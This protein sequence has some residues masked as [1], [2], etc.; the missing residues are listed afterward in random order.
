MAVD[1]PATQPFIASLVRDCGNSGRTFK[2]ALIYAVP[3]GS[4]RIHEAGRDWLAWEDINDDVP[5]KDRLDDGQKQTLDK[6]L[7]HAKSDFREAI[8]RAYR[9]LYL[10]GKDNQLRSIDLG[11]ITSSAGNSLVD[12][13]LQRLGTGGLDEIVEHVPPR[14]LL[15]Y[16]PAS[17]SEWSTK[18]VRDAFYS[19]PQ[20]PRLLNPDSVKRMIADGVTEGVIGYAT[21]DATGRLRPEELKG[22]LFENNVD[23]SDDVFI[24]TAEHALKLK[25][26]P[27]LDKLAIKPD[28]E[29]VK[30]GEQVSFNC[31]GVDQ[32]AEL[33][34]IEGVTWSA[35]GGTITADGLFSAG[36]TGG[37]HSVRADVAGHDARTEVRITTEIDPPPPASAAGQANH[38]L[39]RR[40][41]H[42]KMDEFL[43]QDPHPFRL[44]SRLETGG[45]L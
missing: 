4:H 15:K 25:E 37:L 28:H 44:D 11:N 45:Q 30:V 36:Q 38:S 5:T 27:R 33:F 16:W 43:H 2:S 20:L 32:Y 8:L 41:A 13:Y 10:L 18:S 1:N 17:Q 9:H 24:L 35:T 3:D 22:G 39:E 19:S 14:R 12:M 23:I 21:K 40:G 26:P 7:K 34:A 29:M 42:S 31:S 6:S